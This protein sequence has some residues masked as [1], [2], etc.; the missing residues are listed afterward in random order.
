[1][2]IIAGRY[3]GRKIS[4]PKSDT[5]PT[6]DRVREA[7]FS[8][9]GPLDDAVVVDFFAGSGALGLEALSRGARMATFVESSREAAR[10][11]RDNAAKLG[12]GDECRVV[13]SP[14]ERSRPH[15]ARGP[16]I[17]LVLADPPWRLSA[18]AF[19]MVEE[20]VLGLL[21]RD[22]TLV[23]GH[24]ARESLEPP[25]SSRLTLRSC[26]RWGDS[27]LSFFEQSG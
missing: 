6:L 5:R 17:D 14:V 21:A 18:Q 9:L 12:L 15:L 16:A 4:C 25:I 23:V 2:R 13:E 19:S 20:V 10:V 22:A 11:I 3:R 26:R 8:I 24:A 27:A 1:V 7:L